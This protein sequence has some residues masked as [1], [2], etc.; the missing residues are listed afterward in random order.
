VPVPTVTIPRRF[1]GPP[2][3]A[4]GGYASGLL[5]S[6][7]EGP[8]EV[9]LRAPP[10]LDVPLS[11]ARTEQG[12][13]VLMQDATLIAEATPREFELELPE[14]VSFE[15][16][17]IASRAYPGYHAHPYPTCF[18][19]GPERKPA[20][21]LRL[22]PGPV[23]GRRVVAAP[24]LPTSDLCRDGAVDTRFVWAALDCPSWFGF[25][26]FADEVPPTLLGRLTLRLN[27]RPR[28]DQRCVVVGWSTGRDGRRIECGSMLLDDSGECLAHAKSTWIAL[29]SA[30]PA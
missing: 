8:C 29:K 28:G 5:G 16:A 2:A 13:A 27:R 17:E 30:A 26:S 6:L 11:V 4:N 21:G 19:C 7:I 24:W 3:S 10:P 23:E 22:F 15:R 12:G 9:T 25:V 14:P 20:D 18:V 1:C